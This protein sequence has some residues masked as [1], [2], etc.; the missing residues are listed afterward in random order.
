MNG[1][2][3]KLESKATIA[4]PLP[5]SDKIKGDREKQPK[6]KAF[7]ATLKKPDTQS[8]LIIHVCIYKYKNYCSS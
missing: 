5:E 4:Y 6:K 2:S 1:E 8:I 3:L 7:I